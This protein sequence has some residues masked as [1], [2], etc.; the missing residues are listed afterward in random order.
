MQDQGDC[1]TDRQQML[2]ASDELEHHRPYLEM[3]V[4]EVQEL[5]DEKIEV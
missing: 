2:P 5:V 4:L 1:Q 3:S